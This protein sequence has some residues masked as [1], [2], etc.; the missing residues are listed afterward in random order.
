MIEIKEHNFYID[1]NMDIKGSWKSKI[2]KS[3]GIYKLK[4]QGRQQFLEVSF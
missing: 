1:K 3:K 2:E 4:T